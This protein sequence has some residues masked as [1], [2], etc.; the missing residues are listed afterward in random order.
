[1]KI[2]SNT[3]IY[4]IPGYVYFLYLLL[5]FRFWEQFVF[6]NQTEAVIGTT[7]FACAMLLLTLHEAYSAS[8]FHITKI[9]LLLAVYGI[10][11]LFRFRYPLENEIFFRTFSIVCIY[12]YFR[13]FSENYLKGLLFLLPLA[14]IIQIADGINRF[15]MPWQNLSHITGIF[16]NTGLFGGFA[17]L[18][19]VVCTGLFFFMDSCKLYLKTIIL[20][21]ICIILAVQV[22]ASGS[23]ASWIAASVAISF[24]L[25]R[26]IHLALQGALETKQSK[27]IGIFL[28]LCFLIILSFLSN[29]LYHLKK[30]SADGRLLIARVSMGMVK[31]APLFG[32]GISGFRAEYL[33]YQADYFQKYSDSPQSYLAD[34]VESPFNEFLK[35]LIEQGIIGLLLFD[36]LLYFLFETQSSLRTKRNEAGSNPD[37]LKNRQSTILQ[38]GLLFLLIFG[39]FSYP[40]DKLPFEV[41]FVFFIAGLSRSKTPVVNFELNK[42]RYLRIPIFFAICVTAFVIAGNAYGYGKSCIA[43]NAAMVNLPSDREKSLST[44]KNLTSDLNNNPVFLTTYGKAL[45]FGGHYP[46]AIT[47]LEKALGRLPLSASYIELGKSYEVAGFPEKAFGSWYRA[48]LTVP[49]RFTPLYLTMKLYFKNKEYDRAQEYARQ[50]LTKKIKTDN[51]E[52]DEMK[53]DAENILNFHPPPQ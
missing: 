41:L 36:C 4:A 11:L 51:P 28:A 23:R 9:D 25:Y 17:A 48:S 12:L 53:R 8:V 40:S 16:H 1:M 21:S 34:D 10:Y 43:W 32:H 13:N 38:S 22:Y 2:V 7:L 37:L 50:L 42:I 35:I 27:I 20:V 3:V 29:H 31:D 46:E 6:S 33:N 39:L 26:L 30:D 52:I 5:P 45:S 14:S 15:N 24:L 49:S 18:G 47:V 19:F 44:L